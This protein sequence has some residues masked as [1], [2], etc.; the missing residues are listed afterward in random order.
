[1]ANYY[2]SAKVKR[3]L[4]GAIVKD[5][6]GYIAV[7]SCKMP[8]LLDQFRLDVFHEIVTLENQDYKEGRE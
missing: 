7:K 5:S 8:Y 6:N 4:S 3:Q 1:M 2:T